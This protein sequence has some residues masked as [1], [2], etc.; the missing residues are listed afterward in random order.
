[1]IVYL[2][3][4][5]YWDRYL[6]KENNMKYLAN[7]NQNQLKHFISLLYRDQYVRVFSW[8]HRF[9]FSGHG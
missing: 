9:Q 4:V 1:M 7:V 8:H 3:Y 2:V 5:K 6:G